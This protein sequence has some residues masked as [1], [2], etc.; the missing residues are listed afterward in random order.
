M[1]HHFR[2]SGRACAGAGRRRCL[3]LT[4]P[5][6]REKFH[7]SELC[8]LRRFALARLRHDRLARHCCDATHEATHSG[9]WRR[10]SD[11]ALRPDVIAVADG[12]GRREFFKRRSLHGCFGKTGAHHNDEGLT[13]CRAS[14]TLAHHLGRSSPSPVS[15]CYDSA[16]LESVKQRV[17]R[18]APPLC[19]APLGEYAFL[20]SAST[21]ALTGV[22][23]A[24]NRG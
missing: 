24:P 20:V 15:R 9:A 8:E 19:T 6:K 16:R 5:A 4:S 14:P 12:R 3:P 22:S 17:T 11:P 23:Y 21:S 18:A 1:R 10:V 13:R 2:P 7:K